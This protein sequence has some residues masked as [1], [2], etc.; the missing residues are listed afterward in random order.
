MNE[1]FTI[2]VNYK[3]A[4]YEFKARFE[5]WG[6]THRIAVLIGDS[7]VVFEPDEEDSYRALIPDQS[8]L[9]DTG[10]I[11]AIVLKLKFLHTLI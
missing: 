1:P 8:S 2:F 9:P 5:R 4:E 6:Y 11:E 10:L 3:D 7:T